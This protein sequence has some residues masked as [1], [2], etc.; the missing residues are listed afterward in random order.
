MGAENDVGIHEQRV[1]TLLSAYSSAVGRRKACLVR[2]R[3]SYL[4]RVSGENALLAPGCPLR[5]GNRSF[6]TRMSP[7]AA[8]SGCPL[9]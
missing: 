5:R 1:G 9:R 7:N 6:C 8:L 3:D 2:S 4:R